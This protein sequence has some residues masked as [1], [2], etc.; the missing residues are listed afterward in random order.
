MREVDG[1]RALQVR[2]ARHRPVEVALGERR[3]ARSIR[4]RDQPARALGVRA[5]EHRHVGG[6]LVVARA[7]G[8]QL[9]ADG[10]DELGQAPLDRHVDVLVVG[11]E[12]ERAVLELRR[13][14]VEPAE[15]ARRARPRR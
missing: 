9:A 12:L 1:L 11:C 5:H 4:S 10:A 13:H 14:L 8:V 2:V 7:R 15:Q 6:D 3:A